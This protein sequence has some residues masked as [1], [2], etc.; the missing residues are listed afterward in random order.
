MKNSFK[1]WI[2]FGITLIIFTILIMMVDINNAIRVLSNANV[3]LL[4]Y[5]GLISLLFPVL[6]AIRWQ[7]LCALLKTPLTFVESFQMIMAAWPLGALTPA[8]SGDLIKVVFLQDKLPYSTT[9]GIV[10][11]ERIIDVLV[12]GLFALVFGLWLTIYAGMVTGG[13]ILFAVVV[14]FVIALSGFTQVLPGV[15]REKA[16][17]AALASRV[18]FSHPIAFIWIVIVTAFNWFLSCYQTWICYAALNTDVPLSYIIG[19]L[20][21]TIFAGLLPITPAGMGTRDS[22]VMVLFQDYAPAEINLS[23]GILYSIYGYWLLSILGI[24][25]MKSALQ[26]A[27]EHVSGKELME[28]IYRKNK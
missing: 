28:K 3:L 4:I 1:R 2:L 6:C 5:A 17:N 19:A 20:P 25:F 15:I 16:D 23:I 22:A 8:K 18:M 9:A 24:P 21:V 12:L 27:F 7:I 11:A 26:G 13:F 10:F 14:F